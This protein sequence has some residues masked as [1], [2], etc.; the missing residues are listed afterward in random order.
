MLIVAQTPVEWNSAEYAEIIHT[1]RT[2]QYTG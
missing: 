1:L 2:L